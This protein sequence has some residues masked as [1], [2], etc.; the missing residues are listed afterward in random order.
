M[1]D[2]DAEVDHVKI[3]VYQDGEKAEELALAPGEPFTAD[4]YGD[5][6]TLEVVGVEH[7]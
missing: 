7:Q 1:S 4:L 6:T 2:V 5:K 3:D